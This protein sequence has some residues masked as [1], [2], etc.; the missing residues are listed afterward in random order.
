MVDI[1]NIRYYFKDYS[2]VQE[3]EYSLYNKKE[4]LIFFFLNHICTTMIKYR[5]EPY[6]DKNNISG[7]GKYMRSSK[8]HDKNVDNFYVCDNGYLMS[9]SSGSKYVKI[10]KVRHFIFF[11]LVL[12]RVV[13]LEHKFPPPLIFDFSLIF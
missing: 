9:A 11:C 7:T 2:Q 5:F 3:Y 10:W 13:L 12:S 1:N 6:L 4:Q 8:Y